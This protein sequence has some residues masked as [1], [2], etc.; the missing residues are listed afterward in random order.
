M[1][2]PTSTGA[3]FK[4]SPLFKTFL[5]TYYNEQQL[6][7]KKDTIMKKETIQITAIVLLAL[8]ICLA[9]C[10]TTECSYVKH[11]YSGYR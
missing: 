11:N 6:K 9:G 3:Y 7:T 5:K 4:T 2:P 1:P 10:K 8:A